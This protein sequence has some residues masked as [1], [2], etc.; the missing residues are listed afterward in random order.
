MASLRKGLDRIIQIGGWIGACFVALIAAIMVVQIVCRELGYQVRGAD[1]FTA[2]SVGGSIFFALA[3]TF[4][5]G[6]HIQVTLI[7]E[8]LRGR[9]ARAASLVS[10]FI[11]TMVTGMLALSAANLVYDSYQFEEVAQG[12]LSVPMWIPQIGLLLGALL[13]FL[14]V[15]D[16]F[17]AAISI[18]AK[19]TIANNDAEEV[20]H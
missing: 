16:S 12:L 13:L 9:S 11:G 6:G 4:K 2:W 10:L 14:A 17:L 18:P 8:R 1:D 5:K 15:L 19:R 7:T 20:S 3:Y